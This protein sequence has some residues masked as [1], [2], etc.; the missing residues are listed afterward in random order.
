MH[1]LVIERDRHIASKIIDYLEAKGHQL[2]AVADGVAGLNL[3]ASNGYD[4]VVLSWMLPRMEGPEVLRKLRLDH[5]IPVPVLMLST[6]VELSD[7]II[8]FRSGADDYVTKPFEL[9]E[10]EVRLEAL[11]TRAQ[12]RVTKRRLL[13]GDLTLDLSTLDARRA[14]RRLHLYPACRKLLQALMRASPAAVTRRQL[15]HLLW[16]ENPPNGDLLRSQISSLRRTLDGP[17]EEKMIQTL[18]RVGY[19]L[20]P[21]S[22]PVGTLEGRS[23]D[24]EA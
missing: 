15:E 2:D 6:K 14:G 4:A 10:L 17:F 13:V 20:V 7:K 5:G 18:P 12:G 24:G 19:R 8:A 22:R 1:I 16:G 3:A 21:P 9:P 11:V 23:N